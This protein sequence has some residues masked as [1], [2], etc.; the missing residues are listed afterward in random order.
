MSVNDTPKDLSEL[1]DDLVS[2]WHVYSTKEPWEVTG[3]PLSLGL[4]EA[5]RAF[6]EHAVV[7]IGTRIRQQH[8]KSWRQLY[9]TVP[10]YDYP[11]ERSEAAVT[12]E[13]S[14]RTNRKRETP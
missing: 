11:G 2:W 7:Q 14:A 4:D 6:V 1:V 5:A 9:E 3:E 10:T 12:S 13:S 8:E